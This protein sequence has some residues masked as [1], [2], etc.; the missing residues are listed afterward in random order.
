VS[1]LLSE[2][3]KNGTWQRFIVVAAP[4]LPNNEAGPASEPANG[5]S[6]S[7]NFL[8][9]NPLPNSPG[10]GRPDECEAGNKPWLQNRTVIGNVPGTQSNKT[11]KT[12]RSTTD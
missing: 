9:T 6:G 2:G 7:P 5:P 8:H 4:N 11:E 10:G 12:T 3:D 1:S